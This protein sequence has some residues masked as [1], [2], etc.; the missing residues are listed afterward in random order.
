MAAGTEGISLSLASL[1][2]AEICFAFQVCSPL[3]TACHL[4]MLYVFTVVSRNSQAEYLEGKPCHSGHVLCLFA[5]L[6]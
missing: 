6:V 2:L 3:E 5:L 1:P 4:A